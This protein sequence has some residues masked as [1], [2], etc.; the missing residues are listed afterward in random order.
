MSNYTHTRTGYVEDWNGYSG[1]FSWWRSNK[2]WRFWS[3]CAHTN[4][5]KDGRAVTDDFGNLVEVTA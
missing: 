3:I 2:D 1:S 4:F 5:G